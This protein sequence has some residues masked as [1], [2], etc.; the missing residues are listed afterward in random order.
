MVRSAQAISLRDLTGTTCRLISPLAGVVGRRTGSWAP[1][2]NS[3]SKPGSGPSF[4]RTS[5]HGRRGDPVI[6]LP[7][8]GVDTERIALHDIVKPILIS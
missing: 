5:A 3:C 6:L 7:A 8:N 2:R 1:P 4:C